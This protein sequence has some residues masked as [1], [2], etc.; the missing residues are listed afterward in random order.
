MRRSPI[1]A[2]IICLLAGLA[3][4]TFKPDPKLTEGL[5]PG[6]YAYFHT[7]Y[8]DFVVKLFTDRTPQTTDSFIGLA[9]GTKPFVDWQTSKT[10]QRR[11]YDGLIFHRVV[12]GF[13]IQGGDPLGTG[14]GGPGF[15]I[16]DEFRPE[17]R[18]D[19]KGL[20]GMANPG[21]PNDNGS[22]FFITLSPA[23]HLNDKHT[24]FG[25]VVRGMDT[26]EQIGAVPTRRDR[27]IRDVVMK[28]VIIIK[29]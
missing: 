14:N 27:P 19:R 24:V 16:A 20:L 3:A 15:K 1:P 22:Q 23:P 6:T 7:N 18:F 29:K 12:G 25:Q 28:R 11:F 21:K 26:V 4:C 10:V 8:G 5:V 13:V 17:L 9:E 2:L